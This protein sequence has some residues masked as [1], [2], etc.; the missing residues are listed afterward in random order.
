MSLNGMRCRSG[1]SH[2]NQITAKSTTASLICSQGWKNTLC[3]CF[4]TTPAPVLQKPSDFTHA[5]SG[6]MRQA[7]ATPAS[8]CTARVARFVVV[9]YG[10][11]PGTFLPI[12][13]SSINFS[14]RIRVSAYIG[15]LNAVLIWFRLC[16]KNEGDQTGV[17]TIPADIV[18]AYLR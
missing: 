4:S 14:S 10:R 2:V 3:F 7:A 17:R 13:C 1:Y 18:E 12:R 5:I 6:L 9:R 11:E 16:G 8:R 15:W